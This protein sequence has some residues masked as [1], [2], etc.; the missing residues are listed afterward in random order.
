MAVVINSPGTGG[1]MA[2][3]SKLYEALALG[4]PV[5]A[6]TNPGSESERL[7][8]RLGHDAGCAPPADEA[9]IARAV[10]RLID[11]PPAPVDAT[12]LT[13]FS[14][15]AVAEQVAVLLDRLTN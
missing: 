6:L 7:L 3:P 12:A 4:T 14:R 10:A 1:D 9:A 2:A 5:L 15:A 11:A 13:P 8:E